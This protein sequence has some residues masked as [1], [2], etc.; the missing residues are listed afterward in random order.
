MAH[1]RRTFQPHMHRNN[2]TGENNQKSPLV[3]TGREISTVRTLNEIQ[4]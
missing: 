3:E 4:G 2:M 1:D